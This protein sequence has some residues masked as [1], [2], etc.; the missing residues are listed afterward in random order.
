MQVVDAVGCT[1]VPAGGGLGSMD[2]APLSAVGFAV[3]TDPVEAGPPDGVV[4]PIE[5]Y[6]V[7]AALVG[8]G[9]PNGVF[10]AH[11]LGC[12]LVLYQ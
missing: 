9:C 8:A 4:F 7:G 12:Q 3:G 6:P 11:P 10:P 1:P 2:T 5:V